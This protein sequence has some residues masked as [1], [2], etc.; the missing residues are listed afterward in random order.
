MRDYPN[1][2][3]VQSILFLLKKNYLFIFTYCFKFKTCPGGGSHFGFPLQT[4][5]HT[6]I[7]LVEHLHSLPYNDSVVSEKNNFKIFFPL[8]PM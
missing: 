5:T 6:K 2:A 8:V 3:Q 4:P 1:K 7:H